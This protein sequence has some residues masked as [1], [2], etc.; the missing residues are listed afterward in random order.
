MLDEIKALH[1]ELCQ[2]TKAE[3]PYDSICE[4]RFSLNGLMN[5]ISA[6][7]EDLPDGNDIYFLLKPI[8]GQLDAALEVLEK[9]PAPN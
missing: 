5:L 3:D 2:Q 1:D 8:R 9:I 7:G 4:A 6:A